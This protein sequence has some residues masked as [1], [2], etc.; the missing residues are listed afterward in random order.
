MKKM[1]II[2]ALLMVVAV[3]TLAMAGPRHKFFDGRGHLDPA[4]TE[5]LELTSE[6]TQKIQALHEA[7]KK[8]IIPV[9]AQ[10]ATK[11]AEM[12]LLWT[13]TTLDA[14]KIKATQKELQALGTQIRDIQTDMRIAFRN[15]LTPEQSSKILAAGFGK[16]GRYK[17]GGGHGKGQGGSYY[18]KGQGRGNWGNPCDECPRNRQ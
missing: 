5:A 3:T 12:R 2:A 1:S 18:G 11:R 8:E 13:Q 4:V 9:K 15:L 17:K 6:Q 7:A 16:G 14:A 10:F